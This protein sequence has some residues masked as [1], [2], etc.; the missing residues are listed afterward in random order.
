ML[1]KNDLISEKELD[2][3]FAIANQ[4]DDEVEDVLIQNFRIPKE[5]L[6][7]SL[8]AFY[9]TRYVDLTTAKINVD[10]LFEGINVDYLRKIHQIPLR[11]FSTS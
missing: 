3:A 9:N 6:G 5:D 8:A 10:E 4:H 1:I 2:R 7:N 11:N